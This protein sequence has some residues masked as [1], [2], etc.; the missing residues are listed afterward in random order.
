MRPSRRWAEAA[1]ARLRDERGS[2]SLEF[3]TAGTLLLVPLVY[4]VMALSALQ[5]G[6]L[7][8]EAA[9]RQ[10]TRTF[11]EAQTID[12]ARAR[13]DWAVAFA[14]IDHGLD[15]ATTSIAITC[16]PNPGDCLQHLG[17]VTVTVQTQ[18]ALPLM[19]A[20]INGDVPSSVPLQA[21]ATQQVSRFAELR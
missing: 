18:V 5:S 12:D 21:S 16:S 2:A 17:L 13:A 15:S 20:A 7:A 4:L 10:A 1:F 8:V 3:I 6:S 11:V 19:P 14:L 9:A